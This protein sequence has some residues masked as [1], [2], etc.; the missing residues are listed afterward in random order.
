M[1]GLLAVP[2]RAVTGFATCAP[3]A[4]T[5]VRETVV[6]GLFTTPVVRAVRAVVPRVV[7]AALRGDVAIAR[8]DVFV[9]EAPEFVADDT[10]RDAVVERFIV[11]L[12][13]TFGC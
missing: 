11:F 5:P 13:T 8:E 9:R 1:T 3:R 6:E 4:D 7:L 2:T 10:A 12:C